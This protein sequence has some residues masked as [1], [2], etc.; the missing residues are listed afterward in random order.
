M[1]FS[2][3][4]NDDYYAV[5]GVNQR[6]TEEEIN[7]A[8]RKLALE[9]RRFDVTRDRCLDVDRLDPDEN[10]DP[11]ATARLQAVNK[12]HRVLSD[13]NLRSVYDLLGAKGLFPRSREEL[14]RNTPTTPPYPRCR[15][16]R[17]MQR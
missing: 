14:R 3:K 9:L 8:Y 11:D 10:S 12:A 7:E 1:I 15:Y 2:A 13:E 5:L 16:N 4:N 6:A 17:S